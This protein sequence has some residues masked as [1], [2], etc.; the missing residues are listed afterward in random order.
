M[1]S[2]TINSHFSELRGYYTPYLLA[3]VF[4]YC[5]CINHS[6]DAKFHM[7]LSLASR[8]GTLPARKVLKS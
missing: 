1:Y 3:I 4:A 8:E 5:L 7:T 6:H 2:M